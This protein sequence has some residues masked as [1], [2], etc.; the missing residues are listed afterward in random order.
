MRQMTAGPIFTFAALFTAIVLLGIG[1]AAIL[2]GAIPLGDLRGVALLIAALVIAYLYAFLAYRLFLSVMP[3]KPGLVAI[4]SREDFAVQVN[5]LF[6]L[7]LFNALIKTHFLPVPL[8]RLVYLALGAKLG[9]NTYSAGAI[10]DPP[11]T[12]MG[13]NCLVG[14]D[15]VLFAHAF[16]G[17]RL[18]LAP[19]ELGDNVTIGV[20]AIVMPGVRI[21]S[22]A[23]VSAGAV[24][25]KGT[26]IG[27]GEVWGG[28]PARLLK[29]TEAR[30]SG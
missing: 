14:H 10:L 19:I 9:R 15:A 2:F 24:V 21:G 25:A 3:L 4:G 16:E 11:L 1:T 20:H 29:Q 6:S 5:T 28:V 23:I 17:D 7:I 8:M 18:T 26:D 30:A 27:P 13:D 22:G 12:R